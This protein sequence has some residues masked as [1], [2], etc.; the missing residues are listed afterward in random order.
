ML[1]GKIAAGKSTLAARLAEETG[2]VL[3]GED[4]FLANLYPA[5]IGTLADYVRSVGR[6][7]SAMEPHITNLLTHGMS[8]VLD[9]QANTPAAR[10][11]MRR[12]FEAA[13]ADHQLHFLEASDALCKGRLA[14]RNA[15]GEHQYQVSEDDY[16]LFTSH[17]A[18]PE[19]SEGFNVVIH[20]QD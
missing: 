10:L 19:P 20:R 3:I 17:F 2:A 15:S 5:E 14:A 8:V 7:R 12:I 6:L 11:W 16:D 9:F 1:C 13:A 4:H 18:P